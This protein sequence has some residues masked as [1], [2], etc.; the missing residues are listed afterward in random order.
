MSG[1]EGPSDVESPDRS[2]GSGADG[3]KVSGFKRGRSVENRRS[4]R[5]TDGFA[6]GL[7]TVGGLGTIFAVLGVAVF[8]VVIVAPLFDDAEFESAR[9]PA[10]LATTSADAKPLRIGSDE[11]GQTYWR[12]DEDEFVRILRS[13]TGA[14][15]REIDLRRR[16]RE[17]V[18]TSIG[19]ARHGSA[20]VLGYSDGSIRLCDLDFEIRFEQPENLPNEIVRPGG[21]A[22]AVVGTGAERGFVERLPSGRFRKLVLTVELS[23]VVEVAET[24]ITDCDRNDRS[25]AIDVVALSRVPTAPEP[26]LSHVAFTV[27]EDLFSGER[28]TEYEDQRSLRIE[29]ARARAAQWV[30]FLDAGRGALLVGPR[31]HALRI[32]IDEDLSLEQNLDL[33][34]N[35]QIGRT[36]DIRD[37][38]TLLGGKTLIVGHGSF[39]AGDARFPLVG[40]DPRQPGRRK[41]FSASPVPTKGPLQGYLY[42]VLR[43]EQYD[44]VAAMVQSSYILKLG[45][46][47]ALG[48]LFFVSATGLLLFRRITRRLRA[49]DERMRSYREPVPALAAAG[50]ASGAGEL[51]Q[52][53][54][55]GSPMNSP[56]SS[57]TD[58]AADGVLAPTPPVKGDEVERLDAS[59][60]RMRERIEEQVEQ[61][62][63]VDADRREMVANISHDL[64]TPLASLQG[65]LETLL[66]KKTD[67]AEEEA[68]QYLKVAYRHSERLGRLVAELFELAKLDSGE[69]FP[70]LE[71]FSVA[72]LVQDIVEKFRLRA[73]DR[74]VDLQA[75][76]PRDLPFVSA[77]IELIERAIDNLLDNALR[78]TPSGG[79]VTVG[80]RDAD[81]G[82]EL[83]VQD[84][85]VGIDPEELPRIFDRFYRGKRS[86]GGSGL[87]LA[88]ARRILELHGSTIHVDSAVGAGTS[89]SFTLAEQPAA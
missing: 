33:L 89:M 19:G 36:T 79:Q 58:A 53:S 7:I 74:G 12:L 1:S 10:G 52:L 46:G 62:R 67:L 81:G 13:D 45:L 41:V 61:L 27:K 71:S 26:I 6:R 82:A 59:F 70:R 87:G 4:V 23:R 2:N 63:R 22:C 76:L 37:I 43:G 56:L 9:I 75:E 73:R 86:E 42:V 17:A 51:P 80:L 16:D 64:R 66:L 38:V 72:E 30:R 49:L 21:V 50:V 83:V 25:S 69:R 28:E 34:E 48:S 44:S 3:W 60:E 31:G 77:D 40:D 20:F 35:A 14:V 65:Y 11:F 24:P 55:I 88:I 85:G 68:R 32:S 8:L 78:H 47:I 29:S 57:T 18:L 15:F 54:S 5:F 84:T 39:L